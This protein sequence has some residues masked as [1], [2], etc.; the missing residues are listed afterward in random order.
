[1][2]A[3]T[4]GDAR[5]PTIL[6]CLP[7]AGAGPNVFRS[8][9]RLE[10]EGV[11]VYPIELP[12]RGRQ[13]GEEPYTDVLTAVDGMAHDVLP[14]LGGGQRLVLFGHCLGALL[15]FELTRRLRHDGVPVA[16]LFVSGS[17][18]PYSTRE[19]RATDVEDD[20]EF[21]AALRRIAGYHDPALENRELRELMLPT[22]RADVRMHEDYR[23]AADGVLDVPITAIRGDQD[24]IVSAPEAAQW[25]GMTTAEFDAIE[26]P[27]GH[28]YFTEQAAALLAK[29]RSV[30][31]G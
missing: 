12:G 22:L 2:S 28:M 4:A 11:R 5:E 29:A 20:D 13:I 26:L 3:T 1:M 17:P 16:H 21:L 30:R 7:H 19:Q 14:L 15:C 8:W 27:G 25:R 6:L 9:N 24:D 23:P 31:A 10:V 18:G